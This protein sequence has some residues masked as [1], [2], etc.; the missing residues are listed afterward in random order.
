MKSEIKFFIYAFT[1]GMALVAYAHSNFTGKDV[2]TIIL[3]KLNA[4][5]SKVDKIL[6]IRGK[7]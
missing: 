4:L 7:K 1:L 3:N 5:D 2:S 6:L